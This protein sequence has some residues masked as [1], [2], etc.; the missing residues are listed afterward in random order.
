MLPTSA[1]T[2]MINVDCGKWK[3]VIKQS[4]ILNL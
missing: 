3:L 1:L 4:T 2:N